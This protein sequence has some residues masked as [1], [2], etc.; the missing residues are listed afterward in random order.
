MLHPMLDRK[1]PDGFY[2]GAQTAVSSLSRN[3]RG[4]H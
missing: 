4:R 1:T 3:R 2:Y